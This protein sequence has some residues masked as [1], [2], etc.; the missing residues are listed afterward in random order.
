M[1]YTFANIP[2]LT[3]DNSPAGRILRE[4]GRKLYPDVHPNVPTYMVGVY[5]AQTGLNGFIDPN[6][7]VFAPYNTDKPG[8]LLDGVDPDTEITDAG[9]PVYTNGNITAKGNMKIYG[10]A[11]ISGNVDISGNL[12][13]ESDEHL[14]GDLYIAGNIYDADTIGDS[15]I[16]WQSY[17]GGS[18][19][20]GGT[21]INNA[22]YISI[23]YGIRLNDGD[24]SIGQF[25]WQ[26]NYNLN[27]SIIINATIL[28]VTPSG[29]EGDAF[30]IF[31]GSDHPVLSSANNRSGLVVCFNENGGN[32]LKL[33]VGR[34]NSVDTVN[35]SIEMGQTVPG[36]L[37]NNTWRNVDIIIQPSG[38]NVLVSVYINGVYATTFNVSN[39]TSFPGNYVGVNGWAGGDN[40]THYIRSFSVKSARAWELLHM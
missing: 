39:F 34:A 16:M 36:G 15:N 1:T 20:A 2:N 10:N 6:S 33:G 27:H 4:T 26:R 19:L 35:N 22:S 29:A 37:S 9:P 32:S 24:S 11:D 38:S 13:V 14:S 40:S 25:Y 17:L 5:D 18:N 28:S 23:N 30:N 3:S 21:L 31:I 8:F 7:P 12:T